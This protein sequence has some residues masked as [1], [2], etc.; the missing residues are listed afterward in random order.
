[1]CENSIVKAVLSAL[2]RLGKVFQLVIEAFKSVL[3]SP[4]RVSMEDQ[5]PACTDKSEAD[6]AH[7][8][9]LLEKLDNLLKGQ[10]IDIL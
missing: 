6:L 4:I 2:G 3:F 7:F 10:E 5:L 1:M 8:R 9:P